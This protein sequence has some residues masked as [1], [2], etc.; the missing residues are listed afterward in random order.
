MK[1]KFKMPK[2]K[3]WQDVVY[4]DW[5]DTSYSTDQFY[6]GDRLGTI[7]LRSVGLYIGH[8]DRG[9]SITNEVRPSED[10]HCRFQ[11]TVCTRQIVRIQKIGQI[12]HTYT[13]P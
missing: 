9:V 8:D 7:Y 3:P 12:K 10:K 11:Q 2:L 4:I 13:N 5:E 6:K 1:N